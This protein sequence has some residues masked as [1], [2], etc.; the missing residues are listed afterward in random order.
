MAG[1]TPLVTCRYCKQ[2]INK[3][4]AYSEVQRQYF[5]NKE[6]SDL[7]QHN[8]EKKNQK[9]CYVCDKK[10][11]ESELIKVVNHYICADC[12]NEYLKTDEAQIELLIDYIWSLYSKERQ[13]TNLYYQIKSQVET[14]HNERGFTYQG[15]L[16]A[17]KYC[18]EILG[19]EWDDTYG[20]GQ[21]LNNGYDITKQYYIA[22]KR[23][24]KE[25]EGVDI[26][27]KTKTIQRKN[28]GI[29]APLLPME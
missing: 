5:C 15:M 13:N 14:Y 19:D 2:K 7:F 12:Y 28:N 22:Q 18:I 23:I 21:I 25:L 9:K 8:K 10:K 20:I 6:H 4:T 26:N 1:K 17:M 16:I 29:T 27:M 3:D 11:N 24:K